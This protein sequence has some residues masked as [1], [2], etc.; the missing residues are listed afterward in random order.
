MEMEHFRHLL[1]E[2][3]ERQSLLV[4]HIEDAG[5]DESMTEAVG[6]LS[7]YDQH[8]A[9][10]GAEMVAR[11]QDFGVREAALETIDRIDAAMA[12]IDEGTYGTC[13]GCGGPIPAARLEALPFASECV[14]CAQLRQSRDDDRPVEEE[15]LEAP[16]GRTFTDEA[17]NVVYDGEDAWQDLARFGTANSPQDDLA[18]SNKRVES[19]RRQSP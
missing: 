11:E 16:F 9:D 4:E 19:N 2:E 17:D 8:A 10:A 18:F 14:E 12:R 5:L 13:E 6:E 15:A 7:S 1:R 3:R